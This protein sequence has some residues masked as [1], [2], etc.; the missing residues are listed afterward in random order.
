MTHTFPQDCCQI[1]DA[2]WRIGIPCGTLD[3]RCIIN[4]A[5]SAS[6][7][8]SAIPSLPKELLIC[9]M[10]FVLNAADSIKKKHRLGKRKCFNNSMLALVKT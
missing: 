2:A 5:N 3:F 9:F 4:S 1:T 7:I 8:E 10:N 6:F